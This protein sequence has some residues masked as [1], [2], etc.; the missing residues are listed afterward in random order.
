MQ[1]SHPGTEATGLLTLPYAFSF[2]K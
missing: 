2:P 1:P